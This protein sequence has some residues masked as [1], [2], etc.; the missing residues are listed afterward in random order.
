M[1]TAT[2]LG[3]VAPAHGC[4]LCAIYTTTEA[5]EDQ[6]GPY[7][8][9][10]EQFS[11]FHTLQQGGVEVPNPDGERIS[12][13]ITQF[14]FG[15]NVLPRL[16]VQLNVPVINR[17]Y[18]RVTINGIEDGNAFG[19]GDLSLL[20]VGKPF[21]YVD[22][23]TVAHV[24][25]FAGVKFPSGSTAFLG[26]EAAPACI[27][28][29][30]PTHCRTRA[31]LSQGV[32]VP[33]DLYPHHSIGPPSGVHGHDLTLGS[34]SFDGI[35]GM[36]LFG[37]WQRAFA[38]ASLQY[39]LRSAGAYDYQ[40][41]NDLLFAAGPGAYLLT[42]DFLFNEP[43][44]LRAQALLTGETKGNDSLA[45]VSEGDT[46]ITALYLG[47]MLGFAWSTHLSTEIGADFPVLQHNSGLQIVPDY[48]LRGAVTWR[49]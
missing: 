6:T 39:L 15:Y 46:A 11:Y 23:D 30:D 42:G 18:R 16:G 35:L 22:L 17:D 49:F 10:A 9:V 32:P 20:L 36:Q 48:R 12:S 8:G 28:F 26:E 3:A 34:G 14:I 25:A 5:R 21:S 37:S 29:P 47:P 1:A 43:Y 33:P 24:I 45:G 44:A 2:A 7:L 38:T 4:D 41:A 27:P 40:F 19:A 13:S 31:Q